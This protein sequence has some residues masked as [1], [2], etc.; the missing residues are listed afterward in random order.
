MNGLNM[1]AVSRRE[2]CL[3]G[4]ENLK[5]SLVLLA[6]FNVCSIKFDG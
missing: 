4:G 3:I 5:S 1:R 2:T 6:F